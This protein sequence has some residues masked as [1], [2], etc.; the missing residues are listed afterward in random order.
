[1]QPRRVLYFGSVQHIKT[2]TGCVVSV[3]REDADCGMSCSRD[4][5][6]A[7]VLEGVVQTGGSDGS[8]PAYRK[9]NQKSYDHYDRALISLRKYIPPL[10]TITLQFWESTVSFG[11]S[12]HEPSQPDGSSSGDVNARALTTGISPFLST[13]P[14]TT[15]MVCSDSPCS[16][17]VTLLIDPDME[18]RCTMLMIRVGVLSEDVRSELQVR[19]PYY[20]RAKLVERVEY[21]SH[22]EMFMSHHKIVCIL[23]ITCT[24]FDNNRSNNLTISSY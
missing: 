12:H 17:E 11:S 15:C 3:I 4:G 16:E 18:S 21:Q 1:M 23:Q 8:S 22:I 5:S 20:F 13:L 10:F 9:L 14:L 2:R 6:S 24:V 19:L 7:H